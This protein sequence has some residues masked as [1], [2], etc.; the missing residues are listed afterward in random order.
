MDLRGTRQKILMV[1]SKMGNL[2]GVDDPSSSAIILESSASGE[3]SVNVNSNK[4]FSEHRSHQ[5]LFA[6]RI[7]LIY[8]K[9]K[10]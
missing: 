6:K 1:E 9:G 5:S 7:Y 4:P 8:L 3:G 10:N 2:S